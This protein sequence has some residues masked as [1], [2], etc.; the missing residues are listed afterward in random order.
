M[1]NDALHDAIKEAK[2]MAEHA[3]SQATTALSKIDHLD[4]LLDG[5]IGML[6]NII[7]ELK[8]DSSN[9]HEGMINRL[10]QLKDS[11]EMI[12]TEQKVTKVQLDNLANKQPSYKW[13][14]P[15]SMSL[16]VTV[17]GL[18]VKVTQG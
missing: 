12:R 10:E 1:S 2:E 15:V 8:K 4:E 3:L 14:V 16:L 18:I 6:E 17:V 5:R 13:L 9:K 7:I 11:S